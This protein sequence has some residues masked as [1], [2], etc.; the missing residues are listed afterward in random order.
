MRK[1]GCG[2]PMGEAIGRLSW[3]YIYVYTHTYIYIWYPPPKTYVHLTFAGI[4]NILCLFLVAF[5]S[6]VFWGYHIYIYIFFFGARRL[7]DLLVHFGR[8]A[9]RMRSMHSECILDQN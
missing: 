9:F 5:W 6:L 1:D 8:N 7:H 4:C 3:G 2:G